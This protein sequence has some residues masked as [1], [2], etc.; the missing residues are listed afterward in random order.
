MSAYL[1]PANIITSFS[2]REV[3]INLEELTNALISSDS[4]LP[5]NSTAWDSNSDIYLADPQH[6]GGFYAVVTSTRVPESPC[7][8]LFGVALAAIEVAR[9]RRRFSD[10]H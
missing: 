9:G 5:P 8:P 1:Y 7:L 3:D 2:F 10:R 4:I 6:G